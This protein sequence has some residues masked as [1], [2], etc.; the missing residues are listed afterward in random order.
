MA[1]GLGS[2]LRPLTQTT[3]KCLV[4]INGKP[5]LEYWFDHLADADIDPVLINLHYLPDK[6]KALV[7]TRNDR[8]KIYTVYESNLLGTAGTLRANAWF[9]LNEPVM[10]IHADNLCLSN[11]IT[12]S[13]AHEQRP[14]G[15]DITMMTFLSDNPE[16]CGI[17]ELDHKNI[18]TGF[19][20]TWTTP[21]CF[22]STNLICSFSEMNEWFV[23][24]FG[25]FKS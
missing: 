1:A 8:N 7:E 5:L 20:E 9:C 16:Q 6:V 18:V 25:N 14:I 22:I 4:E 13:L 23:K 11:L 17:V 15:A 10:V 21:S 19:Y 3:P 2:R 24:I 12:F